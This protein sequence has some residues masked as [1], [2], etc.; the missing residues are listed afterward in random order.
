VLLVA[1][2]VYQWIYVEA[3]LL[4]DHTPPLDPAA[5]VREYEDAPRHEL[6]VDPDDPRWG[7]ADAPAQVVVFSSF[8]CPGCRQFAADLPALRERFPRDLSIVFKHYP[9]S[10]TCN[11]RMP[12]DRHPRSCQAAWAAQAAAAQG[13][14]WPFHDGLF[15]LGTQAEE[16]SIEQVAREIGLDLEQFNAD[17]QSLRIREHVA[18]DVELGSQIPIDATPAVF[19]N[20]RHVGQWRDGR[21]AILIHHVSDPQRK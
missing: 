3:R 13:K 21:L 15:A 17:R 10:T 16:A 6:H 18:G 2:L 8:Q 7:A 19:L 9:L 20:G 14:F 11:P 4:R 5:L 1:L 12:S